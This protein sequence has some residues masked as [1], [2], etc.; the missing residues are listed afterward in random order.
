M[1][2]TV[3]PAAIKERLAALEQRP[4]AFFFCSWG[5]I[6]VAVWVFFALLIVASEMTPE[7]ITMMRRL[8]I[9]VFLAP[10][11]VL[12][13]LLPPPRYDITLSHFL[14]CA[15]WG[16]LI[17]LVLAGAFVLDRRMTRRVEEKK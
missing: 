2:Y 6:T 9:P 8:F 1:Y 17:A 15:K 16:P 3:M 12:A 13:P 11:L 7:M 4:W 14:D 10:D 5:A